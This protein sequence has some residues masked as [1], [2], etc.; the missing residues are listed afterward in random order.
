M[1]CVVSGCSSPS[2]GPPPAVEDAGT[3][4][5]WTRGDTVPIDVLWV[6]DNSKPM[7]GHQVSLS[8]RAETIFAS[9]GADSRIAVV[10]TDMLTEEHS[11][12]FRHHRATEFCFA[13]AK[14]SVQY[15]E[16]GHDEMCSLGEGWI[17]DAP[18]KLKNITNCNGSLN[19]KCRRLC[20]SDAECDHAFVGVEQA[21]ACDADPAVCAFKCLI[22]SGDPNFSACVPRPPTADCPDNSAMYDQLIAAAGLEPCS[23]GDCAPPPP[24]VVAASADLLRCLFVTDSESH[25][26]ANLE[27]GI[28][29]ALRALDSAGPRAAQA[30]EFLREDAALL[31]VFLSDEDDCSVADGMTLKK[32][33][34][35]TCSCL[36][37]TDEG[38]PLL[39]VSSAVARLRALKADPDDVYVAAITGDSLA[40]DPAVAEEERAAFSASK[41]SM[42]SDAEASH[43]LL[44]NSYICV[45]DQGKADYGRRYA[46]LVQALGSNAVM[47][48]I[49]TDDAATAAVSAISE[50]VVPPRPTIC[51]GDRAAPEHNVSSVD[52]VGPRGLC[53]DG[54]ACCTVTSDA[55]E[56]PAQCS[57]GG[58]CTPT[59]TALTR[60][61]TGGNDTWREVQSASC[62]G[63]DGRAV[64]LGFR[65]A[66]GATIEVR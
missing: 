58:A 21:A 53:G 40:D 6:L 44:F 37:D 29:A 14:T 42:C 38:G 35:G 46:E 24:Y 43:P 12:A 54:A 19:S 13:C 16:R 26:N 9:L 7:C 41:C 56:H 39:P 31:I 33:L 49:C 3:V 10:T 47:T 2:E 22:P 20:A 28:G 25:N 8:A 60:S 64:R 30:T 17:C 27:Q 45:G 63:S 61:V 59:V 11:G 57:D 4:I 32:E 15:C 18:D 1:V 36:T 66:I 5:T 55:C 50:R 65:P 34:Y 23:T 48:N 62:P 52:R 51:L